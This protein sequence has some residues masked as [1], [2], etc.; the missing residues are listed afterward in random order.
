LEWSAGILENWNGGIL[1]YWFINTPLFHYSN[2]PLFHYSSL[3]LTPLLQAL[4]LLEPREDLF[5]IFVKNLLL[6][7]RRQPGN[8]FDV[9]PHVVVPLA[10]ARIGL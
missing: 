3:P 6:L 9:R 2:I 7:F 10:G 5:S 8:A 4:L 1:S